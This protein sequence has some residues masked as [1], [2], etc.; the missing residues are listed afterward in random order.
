MNRPS[1]RGPPN[2]AGLY[3]VKVDNIPYKTTPDELRETFER[4]GDV[5]DVYIPRDRFTRK[6]RGFAFVR[7]VNKHDAQDSVQGLDGAILKGREVRCQ[8][9]YGLPQIRGLVARSRSPRRR[10]DPSPIARHRS[11]SP[12]WDSDFSDD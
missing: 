4:F 8:M 6:S 12:E 2:I 1:R 9:A 10:N 5:G 3:S 7:F 11:Y